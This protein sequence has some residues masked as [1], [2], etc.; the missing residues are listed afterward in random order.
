MLSKSISKKKKE[1][2]YKFLDEREVNLLVRFHL[3]DI[4]EKFEP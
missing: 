2:S 3:A 1:I 4:E